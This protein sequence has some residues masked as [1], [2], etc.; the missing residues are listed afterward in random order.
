MTSFYSSLRII[1]S[2]MKK[3][4]EKSLVEMFGM[5]IGAYAGEPMVGVRDEREDEMDEIGG[6]CPD[7]DMMVVDDQCGCD[8]LEHDEYSMDDEPLKLAIVEPVQIEPLTI[9]LDLDDMSDDVHQEEKACP[10]C[11]MISVD[12]AMCGCG[13]SDYK[14]ETCSGCGMPASMCK[15][16]AQT[17]DICG[18]MSMIDDQ[19]SCSCDVSGMNDDSSAA[20][21]TR[22]EECGMDESMC[23]CGYSNDYMNE[24]KK[25]KAKKGPSKSTAAKISKSLGKKMSTKAAHISQWSDV[26][27]PWALAQWFKQQ[28]K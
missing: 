20:N 13:H 7:C 17:C 5:P 12:G 15:C 10:N 11:G 23:E 1:F 18:M 25:K 6:I 8:D 19:P 24:A 16:D 27:E 9:K 3:N 14:E 26:N 2:V 22:C 21:D 4:L 28:E